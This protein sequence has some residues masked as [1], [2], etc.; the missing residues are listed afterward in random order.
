[1]DLDTIR[2]M[3]GYDRWVTG[4]LM[5]TVEEIPEDRL[6]ESFGASFDSVFGTVAHLLGTQINWLS[7]WKGGWPTRNIGAD[8]FTSLA[9]IKER[10]ARHNQELDEFIGGLTPERL[11]ADLTYKNVAGQQFTVPLGQLM[12]HVVNHGTH[13][14]SELADMLTRAGHAPEPTDLVRYSMEITGQA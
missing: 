9:E 7:R 3:Y 2:L 5:E 10:W 6:R 11:N 1:M 4:R 12:L 8:D 13:H 14:R